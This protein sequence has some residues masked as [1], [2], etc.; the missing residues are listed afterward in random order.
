M[1][2]AFCVFYWGLI[3]TTAAIVILLL[4]LL[5]LVTI[6]FVIGWLASLVS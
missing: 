1:W 3:F 2:R 5:V 6:A 4:T